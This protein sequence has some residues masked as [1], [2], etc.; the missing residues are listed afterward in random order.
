ME[1]PKSNSRKTGV[2]L[3]IGFGFMVLLGISAMQ[4]AVCFRR[5]G[6]VVTIPQSNSNE[7]VCDAEQHLIIANIVQQG[8]VIAAYGLLVVYAAKWYPERNKELMVSFIP[9]L[10]TC[11]YTNYI[12]T[13]VS[14]EFINDM[15]VM[16]TVYVGAY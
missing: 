3:L 6:F 7:T 11:A 15:H 4:S 5:D 16:C 2:W 1:I 13:Q 8:L 14:E 9:F 12:A 10:L